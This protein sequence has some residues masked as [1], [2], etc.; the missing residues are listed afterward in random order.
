MIACIHTYTDTHTH[1][2][3]RARV[4]IYP[5]VRSKWYYVYYT[6]SC[7]RR[8]TLYMFNGS[9]KQVFYLNSIIKRHLTFIKQS[10][11]AALLSC[12]VL[13]CALSPGYLAWCMRA[14]ISTLRSSKYVC[15][16]V[17][18]GGHEWFKSDPSWTKF[19]I[20]LRNVTGEVPR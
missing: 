15:L 17:S 2:R 1:T 5:P 8:S 14:C 16:S 20:E 3:T 9:H 6:I 4:H 10:P 7:T 18:V 13:S 12:I 19:E 11:G